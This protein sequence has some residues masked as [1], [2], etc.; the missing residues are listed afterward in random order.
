[1]IMLAALIAPMHDPLRIAEDLAVL[2]RISKGRISV[3]VAGGYVPSEFEMFGYTTGDRVRLTVE[4]VETLKAAWT[5]EPFEFRGRTVRVTPTPYQNPRP[6]IWLGGSGEKAARRAAHIADGFLPTM[7][8]FWDF[9]RDEVI[10]LGR[11]DP[12]P[13]TSGGV[14]YLHITHD[15]DATWAKVAP[16]ALHEMNAYGQWADESGAATGYEPVNDADALRAMGMHHLISPAE[17]IDMIQAMGDFDALMF[18]PL[19]GGL[20]PALAWENLR[21]FETE[22]LPHL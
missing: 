13:A 7:P 15:P 19:M 11:D 5:G 4:M 17:A 18:H 10:Q 21:L 3:T 14:G 8:E 20:D 9:Y 12:G 22:V 6:A 1:H 16:H 2:D